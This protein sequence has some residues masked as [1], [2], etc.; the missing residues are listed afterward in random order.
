MILLTQSVYNQILKTVGAFPPEHGGVLGAKK[1]QPVTAFYFDATGCSSPDGY[2]PDVA[3]I[4][5][6]L[7]DEWMPEGILMVG[8]VHSHAEDLSVPSCGDIGYGI[9]ILEA[10]DTVDEF[11]LPIITVGETVALHGYV[12][13]RDPERGYVCRRAEC[14]VVEEDERGEQMKRG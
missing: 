13:Q 14:A 1:G 9:R 5:A 6:V 10:L 11:Y 4:N 3:A 12:I 7:A 2:V 8:I